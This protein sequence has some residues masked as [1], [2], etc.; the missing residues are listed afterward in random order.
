MGIDLL[1]ETASV[2]AT[3]RWRYF[4][5]PETECCFVY[6]HHSDK[7]KGKNLQEP[8]EISSHAQDCTQ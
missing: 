8:L 4:S 3:W 6:P 5:A 7:H 1:L 2:A